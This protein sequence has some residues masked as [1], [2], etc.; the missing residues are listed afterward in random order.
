MHESPYAATEAHSRDVGGL[1]P[2]HPARD[3]AELSFY[4]YPP[5]HWAELAVPGL[6][7]GLKGGPEAPYWLAEQTTAFEA[8]LF[9][10]TVPLILALV[11]AGLWLLT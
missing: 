2:P 10:G 6:F 3:P 7:R 5:S 11:G 9:V 1:H 8:C 4:S